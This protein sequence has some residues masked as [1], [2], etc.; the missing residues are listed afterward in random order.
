[1]RR[2][3]VLF[4]LVL[5]GASAQAE[6]EIPLDHITPNLHDKASLQRGMRTFM[7]YCS[8]CHSMKYERY[9]QAAKFLGISKKLTME[10]LVFN[11]NDRFGSL[12]TKSMSDKN[13]SDFFGQAPPDLTLEA[14][15]RP[16]GADWVYTYLK[17]FYKDDKRPFGV[18]NL[19]FPNVAMP[20]VLENLQGIQ[21]EVCKDIPKLAPNGGEMMDP[22]DNKYVTEKKCGEDLIKRGYS[23]LELVKG[24]GKLTPKQF[25]QVA[26]DLANFL[27]YT[28]EPMRLE[29]ERIGVYV[30]LF[31]AFFF[32]F[33]KLLAREY[34][35]EY[36]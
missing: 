11:P 30:L 22:L 9:E 10:N 23:P 18:N 29:R 12:I 26:Y 19:V 5:F 14:K 15:Y 21:K 3:I 28:A 17:S 2:I 34:E 36:H 1:M 24:S 35:K 32:V 13:A 33:T 20:D 7:N 8:G 6:S 4:V 25:D 27:Y 16:N 31:L